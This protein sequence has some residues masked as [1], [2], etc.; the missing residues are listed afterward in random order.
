MIG[1]RI[2]ATLSTLSGRRHLQASALVGPFA[3]SAERD[4]G[5]RSLM[6]IRINVFQHPIKITHEQD[7]DRGK[8]DGPVPE[9]R[10]ARINTG[11]ASLF[12]LDQC[13]LRLF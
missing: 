10:H 4:R 3:V 13:D 11:I 1:S 8:P 12:S 2:R 7:S 6:T 5:A 9:I